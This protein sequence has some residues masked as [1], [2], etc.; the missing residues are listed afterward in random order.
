LKRDEVET[1]I[2]VEGGGEGWRLKMAPQPCRNK[3]INGNWKGVAVCMAAAVD[4]W[5]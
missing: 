1:R 2:E 4:K 5:A 3:T